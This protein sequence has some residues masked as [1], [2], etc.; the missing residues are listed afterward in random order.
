MSESISYRRWRFS[1]DLPRTPLHGIALLLPKSPRASGVWPDQICGLAVGR[2]GGLRVSARRRC[3][4][5]VGQE[6]V[7]WRGSSR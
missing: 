1:T 4:S 2:P 5:A 6:I 7:G 3:A